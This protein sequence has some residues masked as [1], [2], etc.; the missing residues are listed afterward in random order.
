MIHRRFTYAASAAA[1]SAALLAGAAVAADTGTAAASGV[2]APALAAD[3]G[4]DSTA[5]AGAEIVV[6]A[7]HQVE[8][9]QDVPVALSVL[10]GAGLE[11]TGAYSIADLQQQTPSLTAYNSNPRNSSTAIRGI[12]VSS[13]SD[14]LDTSVGV[15]V[16]NVYLGRPGMALADLVDVDRVEVLRG[17]QG[18]LFGRNSSAGVVNVTTRAPS[19]DF[20]LYA[21]ASGGNY[22]YNQERL[23]IT[24]PLVDGLLAFRVTGFNTHRDG[25]LPN[26]K[27]GT[28]ANS[29]GR[30]GGRVQLLATPSSN[31]KLRWI[32]DYSQEDDTCCVSSTKLV[33]PASLSATTGRTLQALAALGYVPAPGRFTRNNAPQQMRTHQWGTSVQ[34]DWD[35]GFATAT[36]I[37]AYRH[38]YF[39]PLQDSDNTPLDVIQVNVATTRYKQ[40]SQEFRLAS[41][42]GRFNWQAGAYYFH[43]R[44]QD[45]YILNQFGYDASA[46]YTTY[47]R[48]V[49]PNAAAVTIA[50]GSQYLDDVDTH[51]NSL[52]FFGQA[53][54]EITPRLIA[55]GGLRYTRD[56]RA[57]VSDT[58]LAGTPNPATSLPFHYDVEV[59]NNNVSYLG[60]LTWKPVDGL[61]AYVTYSTGYK[62]AGLNLNAAV[63][64]GT[65]LVLEPEKAR[66]WEAGLKQQW[67]GNRLTLNLDVYRTT[68]SG[69]QA[70]IVPSNGNRSYLANVGD[71]L[72][73]GVEADASWRVSPV[74][75]LTANGAYNDAKYKSY[76]NGPC[77]VGV[78]GICDLTGKRVYQSPKWT[79]NAIADVHFET[80]SGVKPY[81]VA[82]YA[83]RS[84]MF[85][86]ADDGPYSV[87][88]GYGIAE[89]RVGALFKQG[90]Y[91]LSAWVQNAFDKKYYLN[92]STTSIVGASPFAFAGQLGAPRTYGVTLRVIL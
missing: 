61:L 38:W 3:G 64:A 5:L 29:I 47:A 81:G 34:A 6:T 62:G 88:P 77:P 82:R 51:T 50:P 12:G 45:H 71:V 72:A 44:L 85:G 68:L 25:T 55:T 13:A 65:P 30:S 56:K 76:T 15:Y 52:A 49:N 36:S 22:N 59:K 8:R 11:R 14:G 87:V 80:A 7:R 46:F 35:L 42:P 4:G 48:L 75:T 2:D 10:S 16:D 21:E 24:G 69:L 66:S 18:T 19:F 33:L 17:P 67:F 40:F 41:G 39:N 54:F 53:N 84:S 28:T 73:K 90:K 32:A 9:A 79:A 70:N 74:L 43:Q 31:F 58:S 86:T 78:S 23:A 63:S 37:T 27:T 20:G 89:F 1:L 60:T 92:L 91:D 57:G 26:L 83:Y